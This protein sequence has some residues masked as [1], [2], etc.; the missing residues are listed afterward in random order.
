MDEVFGAETL[1]EVIPHAKKQPAK[2]GRRNEQKGVSKRKKRFL[3]N[4]DENL[5]K[6]PVK[7]ARKSGRKS[8]LDAI[9]E[10]LEDQ[11]FDDIFPKRKAPSGKAPSGKVDF[12]KSRFSILLTKEVLDR[13]QQIAKAKGI[14]VNDV[15][16]IAIQR[17]VENNEA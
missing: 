17:Y 9:E 10:A 2:T 6:T 13:A 11:A 5:G 14:S 4:I 12:N 8:F 15:I 3:E 7:P 1:A 16:N